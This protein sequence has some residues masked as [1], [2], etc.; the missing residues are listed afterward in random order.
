VSGKF[1]DRLRPIVEQGV[2]KGYPR[3]VTEQPPD[4][5]NIT[6]VHCPSVRRHVSARAENIGRHCGDMNP[7]MT[8]STRSAVETALRDPLL[9]P[10]LPHPS[11]GN[12]ATAT[13]RASMARFSSGYDHTLRRVEVLKLLDA[14]D[15]VAARAVAFE[16]ALRVCASG[17]VV[18]VVADIAF[19]VPT[20]TMLAML[21]VG[22]DASALVKDVRTVVE[23]IGRG[24]AASA[25][26]DAALERLLRAGALTGFDPVSV[27]SVLY[28][29]HDA[30]AALVVETILA[31][32]RRSIRKPAVT[33]TRRVATADT[34]ICGT[35]IKSGTHIVLDLAATGL[36][37]GA[38]PH[39]C[40]G[41]P[42]A[43]AIVDG[44]I[45]AVDSAGFVVIDDP[46]AD[47]SSRPTTMLIGPRL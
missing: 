28:Q 44:I 35:S 33:Q 24:A 11:I 38:G 46:A 12:G 23:V 19:D 42:L 7:T 32:Q 13:L 2:E 14:L 21:S 1:G 31:R 40:P 36:E 4:L 41:R 9:E 18:D 15:P 8:L 30:T 34:I 37:F 47:D 25:S 29:T 27:V 45:A 10:H 26:T 22:S 5:D 6:C 43:E 16:N 17:R 39:A 3:W 20:K